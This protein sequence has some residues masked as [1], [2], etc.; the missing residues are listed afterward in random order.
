VPDLG[1]LERW[2]Q[3][4]IVHP[5]SVEEAIGS[6]RATRH[7][8]RREAERAILPSKTL[9]PL[10]RLAVY[11][12]MYPLRMHDALAA[13]YPALKAFLGDALFE[14]FVLDYVAAHPSRSYTLN[15]LGG[16]VPEFA[17]RWHHPKRAFLADVARLELA[18][19][20]V[21]DAAEEP[22]G[23]PPKHVDADWE[24]R[25][26][27]VNPTLRLLTFRHAA[28]A[29][30]DALRKGRRASTGAKPAW[31][32][33]HRRSYVVYRLDLGRGEFHLLAA[34]AGGA[35]LGK[36]LKAAARKA[37]RPLSPAAVRRAFRLFTSEGLLR[38]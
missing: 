2:M 33:V 20:Q 28:G 32:A 7:V 27:R 4:V 24:N 11:Q 31:C 17:A 22:G 16:H 36:A 5:G 19:T 26:F 14:H 3:A 25:R 10:E 23:E 12:G 30:V 18:V 21:F 8:P 6:H 15:R 35:P 13:D 29:A 38:A 34:I 9:A 37:G 1:A